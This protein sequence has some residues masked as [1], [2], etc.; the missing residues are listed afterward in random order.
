MSWLASFLVAVLSSATAVVVGG[1]VASACVDWFRIPGR[2]GASGYF[3]VIIALLSG[4]GGFLVSFV[5]SRFTGGPGSAGF[6]KG[7]GISAGSMV[8][9]GLVAAGI[10]W[11]LADIPPT[12]DGHELDLVVEVRLPKG[13]PLPVSENGRPF[14]V[15]ESRD[16]AGGPARASESGILDVRQAREQDG[17]WVIPGSVF[18]FTTRGHRML[19]VVLDEKQATGFEVPFPGHPD[20]RYAQWSGWLPSGNDGK[21]WPE[22]LMSYRFRIQPRG[23]P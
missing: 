18:I 15:L 16:G 14:L 19:T 8:G 2:E 20:A 9:L 21:P 11:L 10:A 3:V 7:L 22:T 5:L 12:I 23:T 1:V 17:C 6:F 13:A 4:L